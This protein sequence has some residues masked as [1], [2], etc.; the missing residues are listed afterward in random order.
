MGVGIPSLEVGAGDGCLGDVAPI[1]YKRDDDVE[2]WDGSV[3][4]VGV[5]QSNRCLALLPRVSRSLTGTRKHG[6]CGDLAKVR[7]STI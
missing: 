4:D 1:K 5:P 7:L 3:E 6:Q 2:S